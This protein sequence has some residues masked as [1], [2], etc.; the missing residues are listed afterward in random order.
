MLYDLINI[1]YNSFQSEK[2]FDIRIWTHF[3]YIDISDYNNS[4]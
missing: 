1:N 3:D 4:D 2:L